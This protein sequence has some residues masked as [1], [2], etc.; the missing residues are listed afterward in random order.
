MFSKND[1]EEQ[2]GDDVT[3]VPLMCELYRKGGDYLSFIRLYVQLNNYF[4]RQL[5]ARKQSND[6]HSDGVNS[7]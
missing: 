7:K 2:P 1:A 5:P 3:T 6:N 4:S